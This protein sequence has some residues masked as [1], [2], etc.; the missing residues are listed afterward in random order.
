MMEGN[1]SWWSMHDTADLRSS[2]AAIDHESA[3]AVVAPN[4]L[5]ISQTHPSNSLLPLHEYLSSSSKS[6]SSPSPSSS[7][8]FLLLTSHLP[9]HDQLHANAQDFPHSWSQL[10]LGGMP[11]EQEE[12]YG[13]NVF[14]STSAPSNGVVDV[15]QE[16][17]SQRNNNSSRNNNS[18]NNNNY[19]DCYNHKEHEAEVSN[20]V[21]MP[22][23]SQNMRISSPRSCVTS[24]SNN[25]NMLD[26]S[27]ANKRSLQAE[28]TH[29]H[30]DHPSSKCNSSAN[31]GVPKKP[32]VP[33]S[34]TP[35][36]KV[37]KEKL[38]DRITALHQLVSPFG[39]TDTASVLLEAIGYIRFLQAQIQ[40][41]KDSPKDLSSRGLCLVPI[42]CTH[43]LG[44]DNGADYWAQIQ[45]LGGGF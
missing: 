17:S 26:F 14:Q 10:L 24:L 31:G 40:D 20:G 23:W 16:V 36:L 19:S 32:R 12:R 25:S 15:K 7:S 3:E 44:S 5:L 33:S 42:S 8:S 43:F 30:A 9:H 2:T 28:T 4:L 37:R 27:T 39:K 21:A 34:S 41:N 18:N 1:P 29:H 13:A 11:S 6:P 38:G 35:P 45:S 22:A